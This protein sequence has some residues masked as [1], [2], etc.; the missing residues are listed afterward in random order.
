MTTATQNLVRNDSSGVFYARFRIGGKLTWKSL[1]TTVLT[2]AK[3]RLP[4][5]IKRERELLA[6]G[7]GQITF[8]QA[9]KIYLERLNM[10]PALKQRTKDYHVQR[11]SGLAASWPDLDA[12]KIRNLVKDDC[13]QWAGA[14]AARYSPTS[15]NHTLGILRAII[16]I[17]IENGARYDNPAKTLERLSEAVTP[18]KLPSQ[19]EFEN[20]VK[21]IETS[22]SR[23]S[24]PC[25]NLVRFL[26]YGGFRIGEAKNITWADC[27]F[28]AGKITVYGDQDTGLKGRATGEYRMVPMIP[29]MRLLLEQLRAGRAGEADTSKVM[30]V[31]ECQKA[32]DRAAKVVGMARITHH[33]LR[34]LFATRCIE[35]G[36]DIP[37]VS[38]WLGHKDGGALAMRVYGHLRDAHSTNMAQRVVFS[39]PVAGNIVPMPQEKAV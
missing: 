25:A 39:A 34:H 26:A 31:F 23:H 29:E 17:G 33:D 1:D 21:E 8:A 32:M 18:P 20:F 7:D 16:E 37:T 19:T 4:D 9:K 35:S 13:I 2:V 11:L 14:F 30:S 38:R 3:I 28:E 36:V 27:N 5:V 22:G 12:K 24:R 15:F 6:A 10:N